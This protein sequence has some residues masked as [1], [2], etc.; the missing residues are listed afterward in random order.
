MAKLNIH[1]TQILSMFAPTPLKPR[2][3]LHLFMKCRSL[4][5]QCHYSLSLAKLSRR[6][7]VHSYATHLMSLLIKKL[8]K[9]VHR[10][11]LQRQVLRYMLILQAPMLNHLSMFYIRNNWTLYYQ[12]LYNQRACLLWGQK[13]KMSC[14]KISKL[15]THNPVLLSNLLSLTLLIL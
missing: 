6:L 7:L 4:Q 5:Q 2:R 8:R 3:Y 14:S 9:L 11:F 15:M 1:L 10:H 12:N 13:A